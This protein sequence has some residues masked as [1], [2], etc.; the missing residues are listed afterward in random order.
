MRV[1]QYRDAKGT[2]TDFQ[3]SGHGCPIVAITNRLYAICTGFG[4]LLRGL[5]DAI[6][7]LLAS[8]VPCAVFVAALSAVFAGQRHRAK[9]PFMPRL[10]RRSASQ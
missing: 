8:S 9:L 1:A 2:S 10:L 3:T 5:P 7:A 4:Y 6:A